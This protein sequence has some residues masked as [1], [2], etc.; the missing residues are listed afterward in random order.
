MIALMPTKTLRVL[1]RLPRGCLEHSPIRKWEA[2][3]RVG[4]RSTISLLGF[5]K[6]CIFL[7]DEKEQ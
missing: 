4:V 3:R 5:E 1:D 6:C 7:A 2:A